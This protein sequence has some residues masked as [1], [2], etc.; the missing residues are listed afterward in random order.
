MEK[1][2]QNSDIETIDNIINN[3]HPIPLCKYIDL[4]IKYRN[5]LVLCHLIEMT[6]LVDNEVHDKI[7]EKIKKSDILFSNIFSN[8]KEDIIKYI[9][10]QTKIQTT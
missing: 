8:T 3:E 7:I 1:A 6:N 10:Y 2:I 5:S 9:E 4:V